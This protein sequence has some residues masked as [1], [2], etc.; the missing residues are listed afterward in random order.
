MFGLSVST[1]VSILL[2]VLK[3]VGTGISWLKEKQLLDAGS[4]RA[5]AEASTK[6]LMQMQSARETMQKASGMNET[7]VDAALKDL[8]P[9]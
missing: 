4:D 7:Q 2:T 6:L 1:I 5:L 9:K 8:E 3:L